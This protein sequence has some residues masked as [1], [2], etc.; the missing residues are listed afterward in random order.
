MS[1]A[2]AE[3]RPFPHSLRKFC[4]GL[5]LSVDPH[6]VLA[7]DLSKSYL[8]VRQEHK[9]AL[10]VW[11]D[12]QRLIH[13]SDWSA[14]KSQMQ[15]DPWN[16]YGEQT[17]LDWSKAVE[18]TASLSPDVSLD[19]SVFKNIHATALKN[20]FYSGYEK[21]RI[22]SRFDSGEIDATQRDLLLKSLKRSTDHSLLAGRFRT[23]ELDQYVD[24]GEFFDSNGTRYISELQLRVARQDPYRKVREETI[25]EIAPGRY[26]GE[27][28]LVRNA[29]VQA[30]VTEVLVQMNRELQSS[31]TEWEIVQAVSKAER[32]LISIHPFVDGNGRSIRLFSDLVLDRY[33]L[34]PPLFPNE[35]DLGMTVAEVAEFKLEAMRAYVVEIE[36]WSGKN[37]GWRSYSPITSA[38]REGMDALRGI[39]VRLHNGSIIEGTLRY[40]GTQTDYLF[41][42]DSPVLKPYLDWASAIRKLPVEV[43]IAKIKERVR[44]A[45]PNRN[46]GSVTTEFRDRGERTPLSALLAAG[47][48]QCREHALFTHALLEKA[49]IDNQYVY[50]RVSHG[51]RTED[52]AF[53]IVGDGPNQKV[54]D[55]FYTFLD[56]QMFARVLAGIQDKPTDPLLKVLHLNNY[57]VYWLPHRVPEIR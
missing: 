55:A 30:A 2:S 15:L 42:L 7:R 44:S 6:I 45:L 13:R 10:N 28:A 29:D 50:V 47:T 21:R 14:A 49:G 53:V 57:P 18:F 3:T 38:V 17:L 16:F 51:H 39:P 25:R 23:E 33:G 52:H 4:S 22:H 19:T 35:G 40:G 43:R 37:Y 20:H 8:S 41:D 34:P 9:H 27:I 46:V 26:T 5:F 36:K 24:R 31:G 56:D 32:H 11:V 12:P 1:A 48:G 54:V